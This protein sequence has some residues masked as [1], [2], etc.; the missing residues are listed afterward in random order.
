MKRLFLSTLLLLSACSLHAE[1][2]AVLAI[3][4]F[5]DCVK[6][7]FPIKKT[8]PATCTGP[9]G[10]TYVSNGE[11]PNIKREICKDLCGDGVCQE[12]VCQAV[13]CPCAESEQSCPK[14]C[15]H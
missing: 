1:E 4:N 8:M 5:T 7:G 13:G 2:E 6:A 14:D 15:K 12:I 11:A 10:K 9:D 3:N